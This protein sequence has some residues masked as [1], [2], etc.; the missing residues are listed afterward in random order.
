MEGQSA[1]PLSTR[2]LRNCSRNEAAIVKRFGEAS[3][4]VEVCRTFVKK[5]A[6]K[7]EKECFFGDYPTLADIDSA[8]HSNMSRT[9]LM[10]LLSDLN[11]FCGS[12]AKMSDTQIEEC[13]E[14][15]V[16]TYPHLK[17]SELGMFFLW[18]KQAKYGK[19]YGCVDPLLVM[20]ALRMFMLD[21]DEQKYKFYQ[22]EQK[23]REEEERKNCVSYK[24]YR[25]MQSKRVKGV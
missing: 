23:I 15:V 2:G 5:V 18:F 13:A 24:E 11:E 22:E 4:F 8:Y 3:S 17:I 14:I 10:A 20:D 1:R 7:A 6:Y 19:F 12:R 9:M 21:R 16:Y 25:E